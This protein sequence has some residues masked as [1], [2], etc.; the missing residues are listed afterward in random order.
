VAT[1]AGLLAATL[2]AACGPSDQ[3][4]E[5]WAEE[6][7]IECLDKVC[8]RDVGPEDY[9]QAGIAQQRLTALALGHAA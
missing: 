8:E 1:G 9:L 6:K 5:Q 7:R 4:K 2:L 3:H